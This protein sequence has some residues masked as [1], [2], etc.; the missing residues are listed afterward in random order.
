MIT[1][2]IFIFLIGITKFIVDDMNYGVV[3]HF[4]LELMVHFAPECSINYKIH[5]LQH[6]PEDSDHYREVQQLLQK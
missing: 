3:V 2:S 5:E 6:I 1:G 4:T